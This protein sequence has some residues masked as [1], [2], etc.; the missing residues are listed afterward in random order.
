MITQETIKEHILT[1]P[2]EGETGKKNLRK[3]KIQTKQKTLI[4]EPI[5]QI[6]PNGHRS[7]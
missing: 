1:V 7:C 2:D 6:Q 4:N 5:Q 3:E